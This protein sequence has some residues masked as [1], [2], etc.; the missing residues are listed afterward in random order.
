MDLFLGLKNFVTDLAVG[1]L[2]AVPGAQGV[3]DSET[4]KIVAKL[5]ESINKIQLGSSL[6][7]LPTDSPRTRRQLT[8]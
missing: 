5:G 4:D 1:T 6:E 2:R 3:I 8:S 7:A